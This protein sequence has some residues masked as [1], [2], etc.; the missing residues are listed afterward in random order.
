MIRKYVVLFSISILTGQ[1]LLDESFNNPDNLPG[2]WQFI[3]DSYPTNTGQWQIS[4]WENN[5]NTNAPSATYYWSPSVPNSF[6]YPYDGHYLYSPVMNVESETNV[7]V[8]FQIALDGYPS[9]SGHYNG[10]NIEYNSDGGEWVTALNYEISAGGG[11][12]DIY[13]RVESF[14][15]SMENTLQL[16]WETY[17]TNSYY[18]DAWH[19]DDVKVDVIPSISN[20]SIQSNNEDDNQKGI[21]G[22]IVSLFF[23]LPSNPD[24]GSPFVLINSTEVPITNT[25]NLNYCLLY[26]SPSPRDS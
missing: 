12:V 9:P 20:V 6:A 15:A 10:M 13:P 4:S 8:R 2:G 16:R 18:I 3:P 19:V 26:T 7:I 22:D 24:P 17:G 25:D 1:N 5:F 14:Y 11:T 23:T 21:P